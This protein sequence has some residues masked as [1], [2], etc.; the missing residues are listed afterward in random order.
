M[1]FE[2]ELK[3]YLNSLAAKGYAQTTIYNRRKYLNQFL[4]CLMKQSITDLKAVT[5]YHIESYRYFLKT[6]LRPR[7]G[8]LLSEGSY[9]NHLNAIH[10]F[11]KWLEA[12]DRILITPLSKQSETRT[13]KTE[14][15]PN[16]ISEEEVVKILESCPLNT[17]IGLRDRAILE[18]LYSTGIRR[19]ELANL[20]ITDYAQERRELTIR[21][22]KGQKDRIVPVGE[23]AAWFLEA[24]LKLIRPWQVK[25]PEETAL[26]LKNDTGT[27]LKTG[28]IGDLVKKALERSRIDKKVT[29]HTFRHSMATH[30]LRNGADLRHIQAILG[31]ASLESTQVYTH[32]SVE[33]LK[34]AIKKAHPHGKQRVTEDDSDPMF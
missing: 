21:K 2:N 3:E 8:Q 7:K 33:N 30:L 13:P 20:N 22:G 10:G 32:L 26:F 19:Q 4:G 6:E 1:P 12:T 27:R 9:F 29:P 17:P 14:Q 16:I 25:A 11:F 24:Y 15:L 5:S 23:Y 28:N 18:V 34:Q 31:H